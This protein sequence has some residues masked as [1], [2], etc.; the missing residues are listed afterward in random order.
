MNSL[1]LAQMNQTNKQKH[2]WKNPIDKSNL[3]ISLLY[4]PFCLYLF[5]VPTITGFELG[6]Q[7]YLTFQF[8]KFTTKNR[9]GWKRKKENKNHQKWFVLLHHQGLVYSFS[10]NQSIDHIMMMATIILLSTIDRYSFHPSIFIQQSHSF[11]SKHTH[12]LPLLDSIFYQLW[13]QWKIFLSPCCCCYEQVELYIYS[14][15]RCIISSSKY[16]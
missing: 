6:S 4:R 11:L 7:I 16:R 9:N 5:M 1:I 2:G 3:S 10:T 14:I 13:L 15:I 8:W 12:K